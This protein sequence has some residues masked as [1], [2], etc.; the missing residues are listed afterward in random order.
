MELE[1]LELE[2]DLYIRGFGRLVGQLSIIQSP[3]FTL[4]HSL[5][6]YA[7]SFLAL[8]LV[9]LCCNFTSFVHHVVRGRE[10]ASGSG[11]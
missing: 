2:Y 6:I 9:L 3:S 8:K 5:P 4:V 11:A 7:R 10:K 1:V